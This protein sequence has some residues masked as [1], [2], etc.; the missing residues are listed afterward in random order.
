MLERIER[1][2]SEVR[3]TLVS[4][5][6][7]RKLVFHDSNN[8][9]SMIAPDP[10][11]VQ[12]Y[13]VT[14]PIFDMCETEGYSQNTIVQVELDTTNA[15]EGYLDGILRVN[16]VCNYEKWNLVGGKIRPMQIAN[17]VIDLVDGQKFSCSNNLIFDSIV[18]LLINKKI[19][20][21]ALLFSIQD[22]SS[23]IKNY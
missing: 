23:E 21:Y 12:R 10:Q 7:I 1:T 5:K 14:H 8:A 3:E 17:R 2:V 16:I 18:P 13:I 11:E 4:D 6:D 15:E 9:L 20:G 22:G 19:T